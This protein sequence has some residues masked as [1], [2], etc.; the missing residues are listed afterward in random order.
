MATDWPGLAP[1]GAYRNLDTPDGKPFF[2]L[3]IPS[4]KTG[5]PPR[6]V[7][8]RTAARLAHAPARAGLREKTAGGGHLLDTADMIGGPRCYPKAMKA[9]KPPPR[10]EDVELVPDAAERLAQAAKH[11]FRQQTPSGGKVRRVTPIKPKQPR[12]K[13]R[14]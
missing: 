9:D 4:L 5:L 6:R 10:L 1:V 12:P 14:P 3:A 2:H 8:L 13:S 7:R 11:A